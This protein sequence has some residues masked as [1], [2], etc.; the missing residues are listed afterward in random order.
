[1]PPILPVNLTYEQSRHGELTV[2]LN[3][4][5]LHSRYAPLREAEQFAVAHQPSPGESTII[6]V[7]DGLG[8]VAGALHHHHR[9]SRI[10]SLEVAE[11]LQEGCNSC[12]A[13]TRLA[14]LEASEG[15]IRQWVRREVP[16]WLVSRV[17]VLV[18]PAARTLAPQWVEG[19]E[20]A[21]VAALRDL[22][23]E[24]TTTGSFG[25][26][27]L[28]N[29][30]GATVSWD[31]R[32]V[33]RPIDTPFTLATSGPSL[34]LLVRH[35]PQD[36]GNAT[37]LLATSSSLHCLRHHGVTPA[38]VIH[39]DGGFWATR[40][41][42][43][44]DA[45]TVVIL[46]LRAGHRMVAHPLPFRTR[47]VGEQLAPD[48]PQWPSVGEQPT[49][50]TTLLA[51]A[52][53]LSRM[54]AMTVYG[55][56]LCT[57]DLQ[58]HASPH[59]NDAFLERTINRLVS[60]ETVAAR[61]VWPR[62]V[63][64]ARRWVSGEA[65]WQPREM[66]QYTRTVEELLSRSGVS[67]CIAAPGAGP[68]MHHV[69]IPESASPPGDLTVSR[70][71]TPPF[72]EAVRR[73]DGATRIRH[74]RNC[75]EKWSEMVMEAAAVHTVHHLPRDTADLLLHLAPV[76]LLKWVSGATD[77]GHAA[78]GARDALRTLAQRRI[79]S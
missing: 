77:G 36:A 46:P 14:A 38:G 18:W 44:L 76:E 35:P 58:T 42:Q 53:G 45:E 2:R 10:L 72:A 30:V 17:A 59:R 13:V 64:L 61:G 26:R 68:A 24:L 66:E 48:A 60:R 43:D 34:E 56:D 41:L 57:R 32:Y 12:A 1:M 19:V 51:V 63:R 40:F 54:A 67:H 65:A 8:V 9:D 28:S 31:V 27:W 71:N 3:S 47:W 23:A 25:R 37:P 29:A 11:T 70:K 69:F 15:A 50:G 16:P 52:L 62:G 21:V 7:G 4:R 6:L 79:P 73:P 55:L 5:Y 33:P 75:L 20:R 78:A 49:V 74:A 22:Q 39:T